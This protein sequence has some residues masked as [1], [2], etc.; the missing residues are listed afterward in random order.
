MTNW[1]DTTVQIGAVPVSVLRGGTG[2]PLLVLHDELGFPGIMQWNRELAGSREL[3]I[4]YQ[5]GCGITPRIDWFRGYRDVGAFYN[6]MVRDLGLAP[7]DVI[8]FSA[9]G[10]IAAEMAAACP[11]LIR[12]MMLVA[13]LGIRPSEGEIFDF[14]AVPTRTHVA[15]TVARREAPEFAEIYGGDMTPVAFELFETARGEAAR[16]GWEPFMY[17]PSLPFRL[18]GAASVPT[19]IAWGD[20]DAVVPRSCVD[21]YAAA[22]PDS[23]IAVFPGCGHRP[24]IE[25]PDGF[26]RSVT[27]FLSS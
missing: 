17:D 20:A 25:D 14:F 1:V 19:L 8:G 7:L 11:G 27:A 5:P 16:L 15:A 2:A 6:R 23:S 12:R 24:E 10:Y 21:G 18:A 13:P 26:A 9:G 3:I 22:I 4:P